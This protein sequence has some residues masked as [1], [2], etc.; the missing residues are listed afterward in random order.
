MVV[1]THQ[2]TV[3]ETT[4][5]DVTAVCRSYE[6]QSG[7]QSHDFYAR[8]GAGEFSTTVNGW[9]AMRW[10]TYFEAYLRL[11]PEPDAAFTFDEAPHLSPGDLV[12]A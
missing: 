7:I 4:F 5:G 3:R 6:E 1:A 8:Y 2:I 10:A 12:P 9:S 11:R